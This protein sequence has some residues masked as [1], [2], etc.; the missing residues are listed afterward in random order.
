MYLEARTPITLA[1]HLTTTVRNRPDA[2]AFGRCVAVGAEQRRE[3]S[4]TSPS[5][6]SPLEENAMTH[7]TRRIGVRP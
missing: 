2:D 7:T 5:P 6:L 4:F 3:R 1:S